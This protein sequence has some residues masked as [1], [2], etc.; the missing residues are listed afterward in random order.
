MGETSIGMIDKLKAK[1]KTEKVKEDNMVLKK[2]VPLAVKEWSEKYKDI[3][4][5]TGSLSLN[6][7]KVVKCIADKK[8][9]EECVKE[10]REK[11]DKQEEKKRQYEEAR[12]EKLTNEQRAKLDQL[13]RYKIEA[14]SLIQTKCAEVKKKIEEQKKKMAQRKKKGGMSLK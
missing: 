10:L 3:R 13:H 11:F 2:A 1:E 9:A 12:Y 8:K 5:P 14:F 6:S 7:F 4:F